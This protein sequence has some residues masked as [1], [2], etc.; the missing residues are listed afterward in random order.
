MIMNNNWRKLLKDSSKPNPERKDEF[1]RK[2][3]K[4][5][6]YEHPKTYHFIC[7]Q[8]AYIRKPVW[9][10]SFLALMI[11][12]W[13]I[14]GNSEI[15]YVI[16][17]VMPFVSGIAVMETYRSRMHGM[18]EMESITLISMR[19][20]LFARV[21]CI[22]ISHIL[23]L[24]VLTMIASRYSELGFFMTGSFLTIPY[25]ISSIVCFELERSLLG[26]KNVFISIVV[27]AIVSSGMVVLQNQRYLFTET[28]KWIWYLT[29]VV[30]IILECR[31]LKKCFSWEDYAWN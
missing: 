15:V 26:R 6:I 22:G 1:I 19:G 9:L 25:L 4:Y 16:S 30:L 20:I 23:L 11:S 31:S 7:R 10:I 13:G 8:I 21:F 3:R 2:C 28:Y 18:T 24:L 14:Y 29:A 5:D 27:S 12:V 17:A